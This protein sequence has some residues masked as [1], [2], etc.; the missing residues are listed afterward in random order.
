MPVIQ[1]KSTAAPGSGT[2]S[3]ACSSHPA[4]LQA[5][6]GANILVIRYS[7]RIQETAKSAG[8][9]RPNPCCHAARLKRSQPCCIR[10]NQLPATRSA[11]NHPPAHNRQTNHPHA[12]ARTTPPHL[13]TSVGTCRQEPTMRSSRIRLCSTRECRTIDRWAVHV[14]SCQEGGEHPPTHVPR[15]L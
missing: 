7:A 10:N 11:S 13:S 15:L 14:S 2:A 8:S 4:D 5:H 9:K 6:H 12:R 1:A 3:N